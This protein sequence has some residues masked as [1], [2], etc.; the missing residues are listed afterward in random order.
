MKTLDKNTASEFDF[1]VMIDASASMSKAS[2]RL[3]GKNRWQELQETCYGM[4]SELS[5]YDSDGIDIV[6]FGG[7]V[8]MHEGVTPDHVEELFRERLPRGGTPLA[9]ALQKVV[10]KQART[11]KNTV[12]V[13]FT[14]GEP[15]S[16]A[17]VVNT[18]TRAAN[19]LEKDEALTFLFVQIGRDEG[20]TKFLK[21]L[22]D[23][24]TD[25]KWDIVDT[26]GPDEAESMSAID[27]LNKA[28]ND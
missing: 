16:E 13:V 24:L 9:P 20:A 15:D 8:T 10:D 25:V 17:D 26:V 23:G 5:K 6:A 7:T 28:I 21:R 27:L 4:C 2:T 1:V 12:A 22:D 19:A 11:K 3:S 18:I 14:D